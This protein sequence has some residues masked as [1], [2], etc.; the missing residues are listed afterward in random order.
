MPC[1]ILRILSA[2]PKCYTRSFE[3][4]LTL[5]ISLQL[6]KTDSRLSPGDSNT[7]KLNRWWLVGET[8]VR[9][10]Q[11][12]QLTCIPVNWVVMINQ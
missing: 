1:D 8:N 11:R 10:S 2:T 3:I 5:C 12:I 9:W 6:S 4:A 7:I